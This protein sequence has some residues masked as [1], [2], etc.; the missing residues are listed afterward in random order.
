MTEPVSVSN[1]DDKDYQDAYLADAIRLRMK[2]D[3]KRFWAGDNISNYVDEQ[4]KAQLINEATVAF[5]RVLDTLLIDRENDPNSQ[6]TARRLAKMYFDWWCVASLRACV[7]IITNLLRV[8]LILE[9]LL[10]PNSLVFPST[11]VSPSG[12]RDEELFK[13]SCAWTSLVRLN[14]PLDPEMLLFIFRLPTDVVRIVVLWLTVVLP[15]LPYYV[16]HLKQIKV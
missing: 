8:W 1:I 5:E 10:A 4:T 16:E 15:R 6:G 9:S 13:R 14:L 2:R 3:N 7:A 12:V 11:P